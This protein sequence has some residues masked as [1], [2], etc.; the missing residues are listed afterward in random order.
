MKQRLALVLLISISSLSVAAPES[1][2]TEQIEG[3]FVISIPRVAVV[4]SESP[5]EDFIIYRV[6]VKGEKVILSLYIGNHPMKRSVPYVASTSDGL[7][8][9]MSTNFAKWQSP[10]NHYHGDARVKL[11]EGKG[12]PSIAHFFYSDNTVEEAKAADQIIR[13]FVHK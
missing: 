12:W 6:H 5:V 8:G 7:L 2:K 4:T 11:G 13:S 3:G 1:I 9:G 10:H